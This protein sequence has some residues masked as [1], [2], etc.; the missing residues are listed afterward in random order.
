MESRRTEMWVESVDPFGV[1]VKDCVLI[2]HFDHHLSSLSSGKR[3]NSEKGPQWE[4]L[5]N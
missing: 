2:F 3:R 4:I 5:G 1:Q